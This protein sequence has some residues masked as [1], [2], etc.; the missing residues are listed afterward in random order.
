MLIWLVLAG[1]WPSS[2]FVPIAALA[3]TNWSLTW[4]ATSGIA[5][6]LYSL[7]IFWPE[8]MARFGARQ[9]ISEAEQQR[10]QNLPP[11]H[12]FKSM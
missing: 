1:L 3:G 2:I 4:L 11:R 10:L 12:P 9:L 8:R 5:A 7:P 6:V